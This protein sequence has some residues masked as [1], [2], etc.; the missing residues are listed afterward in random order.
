MYFYEKGINLNYKFP[1]FAEDSMT[2]KATS[3]QAKLLSKPRST[4]GELDYA[5]RTSLVW[6][7][8]EARLFTES[9]V[10]VECS[11]WV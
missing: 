6:L 3:K 11:S 10:K 4:V 8:H 7:R 1:A 5:N 9:G 2:F